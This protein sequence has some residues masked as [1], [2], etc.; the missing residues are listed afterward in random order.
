[1][2]SATA[3]FVAGDTG[4]PIVGAGIPAGTTVLTVTNGTTVQMSAN[5]TATAAGVTVSLGTA[6]ILGSTSSPMKQVQ[7]LNAL[8]GA[9][10]LAYGG[11]ALMHIPRGAMHGLIS[12]GHLA[13]PKGDTLYTKLGTPIAVGA[14]YSG[15]APDGSAPPAGGA[16]LHITTPVTVYRSPIRW[17]PEIE[18]Q[19]VDRAANT[20]SVIAERDY[21]LAYDTCAH[22]AVLMTTTTED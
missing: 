15:A 12:E 19:A 2:T 10:G 16:W 22:F 14:G 17:V 1:M 20:L 7:A 18:S 11:V 21:V 4:K 3:A 13:E 5:A 9:M 6:V 8:E